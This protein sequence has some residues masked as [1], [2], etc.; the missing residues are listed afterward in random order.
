MV[1][2]M[3][4]SRAGC[5]IDAEYVLK[6]TRC[7]GR[8]GID[9]PAH[10]IDDRGEGNAS[11][12]KCRDRDFVG[13][14][15]LRRARAALGNC[16]AAQGGRGETLLVGRL[17]VEPRETGKVERRAWR[18]HPLRPGERAGDRDAHVGRSEL[19]ERRTVDELDQAVDDRL[20][21]D[22][23]LDAVDVRELARVILLDP[24][25][26]VR[27]LAYIQPMRS[28]FLQHDITSIGGAI[29]MIIAGIIK[30]QMAKA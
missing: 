9:H 27:V 18:R 13:G 26:T 22:E 30:K 16:R 25:M 29:L 24:I 7:C 21:V 4:R 14:V 8:V 20:R 17:E 23:N 5:G 19:C 15:E 6:R 10:R 11:G 2:K 1:H 12:K 3:L 28:R